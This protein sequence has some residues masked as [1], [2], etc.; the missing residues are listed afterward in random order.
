[1][2]YYQLS[3]P[4]KKFDGA[5]LISFKL[6]FSFNLHPNI[7]NLENRT[8]VSDTDEERDSLRAVS[9]TPTAELTSKQS[10]L[11]C[12][13]APQ[14][15]HAPLRYLVVTEF[16]KRTERRPKSIFI[17]LNKLRVTLALIA[18]L[19]NEMTYLSRGKPV[20]NEKA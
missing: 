3:P 1:M 20:I 17:H 10:F 13:M 2:V 4:A 11:L 18:V 5:E 15:S 16:Y 7:G 12:V 8:K 6:M 19:P 9:K 14:F